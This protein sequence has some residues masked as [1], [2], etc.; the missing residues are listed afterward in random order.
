MRILIVDDDQR[1][2]DVLRRGLEE[3]GHAVDLADDGVAALLRAESTRH[4]AIVLDVMLPGMDGFQV[5]RE[6]RSAGISTPILMLTARDTVEDAVTGL[7]AGADDYLRKP[8]A[9]R[10]LRARLEAIM[11]RGSGPPATQLQAGDLILDLARHEV[12]LDNRRI[13][14][15]S[16]EYQMLAYLMQHPGRVLTRITIETQV[17]GTGFA[18]L[19]NTV[20]VHIKRLRR[21]LDRPGE[22]SRIETIR[23][24]GYRLRAG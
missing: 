12:R 3:E 16:R 10:E 21:K 5:A 4:D 8:F 1:L 19:S 7:A 23:G 6:L 13:M 15:T 14:L 22:P 18:G 20:D 24:A 11:R 2:T 9:F 17:W